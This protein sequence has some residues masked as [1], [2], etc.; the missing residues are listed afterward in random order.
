MKTKQNFQF[1]I[2]RK[3]AGQ[4][5][6]SA[7]LGIFCSFLLFLFAC[8]SYLLNF[9]LIFRPGFSIISAIGLCGIPA[10]FGTFL[11][12]LRRKDKF[13]YCLF[14][15][16]GILLLAL[17]L[18]RE[19]FFRQFFS[20]AGA[21]E[22]LINAAYGFSIF[23]G[24]GDSVKDKWILCFFLA[25]LYMLLILL[26]M[27]WKKRLLFVLFLGLPGLIT[28]LL[29]VS[30]PITLFA[31]PLGAFILWRGALW[32]QSVS[33][34]WL[35]AVPLQ[36]ILFLTAAGVFTPLLS[37]WVFQSSETF[38]A[39]INTAGNQLLFGGKA[40]SGPLQSGGRGTGT[41][42]FSYEAQTDSQSITSTPPSYTSQ[43]VLSLSIDGAVSQPLYL[44][45][46]VGADY[47]DYQWS[48]PGD[49]EWYTY[50]Q[51]GGFSRQ[52]AG[53]VY[54]MP[55]YGIPVKDLFSLF[56]EFPDSP[57]FTYLPLAG[58]SS[59]F[60]QSESNRL[61]DRTASNISARCF[62]LTIDT[63]N[64]VSMENFDQS[65]QDILGR[66]ETF[67][68]NRYTTWEEQ[69]PENLLEELGQLPVYSSIPEDPSDQ[70]IRN[71]AEEIQNF[72]WDHA[73]YSLALDS[74]SSDIP[75][76]QELLYEQKRGFCI[77][78]ATV[79]TQLFRMYGIPARYVSGYFVLPDMLTENSQGNFTGDIPDSRAHA[80]VEVYTQSAG[81]I[82]VEVTPGSQLSAAQTEVT[83]ETAPQDMPEEETPPDNTDEENSGIIGSGEKDPG[84]LGTL[85][86]V[87][88][89][90]LI[91]ILVLGALVLLLLFVR[92]LLFRFRLGY[93]AGSPTQAYLTVFKNLIR[94]WELEFSIEIRTS[95]DREYFR[96]LSEKLPDPLKEEF[97]ALYTEAE[98]FAYGQK[99]PFPAQLGNLRRYYLRQRKTYIAGK[100]GLEKLSSLLV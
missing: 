64:E 84:V 30:A 45:G 37:P 3:G 16:L 95:S 82:P 21:L 72:L 35:L 24:Y 56:M 97:A 88:K 23:P 15:T 71:A 29:E 81:W 39:R 13:L 43:N 36:G 6:S 55:L 62:P 74:F 1:T 33:R 18:F 20:A 7:P 86:A 47:R 41:A 25:A 54:N 19:A 52:Q 58:N 65:S 80:W 42:A 87:G 91:A 89:S 59:G 44:R 99:K 77:H 50:A 94:L 38:S 93:F 27:L 69:V 60:S 51:G 28:Y 11:F 53:D 40:D 26:A 22:R 31:L 57:A 9:S 34:L 46:F 76:S 83:N 67:C 66:Y 78:F 5:K 61:S 100:K 32:P 63:M 90:F 4:I 49:E 17:Y 70:D 73:S 48:P 10:F 8:G 79:G 12:A 98:T 14:G 85:A 96:L 92:R 75:L 2:Q 68:K